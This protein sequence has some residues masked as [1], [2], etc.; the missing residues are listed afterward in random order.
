[1]IKLQQLQNRVN[2]SKNNFESG[3]NRGKGGFSRA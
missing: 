3:S 2:Q 1:M